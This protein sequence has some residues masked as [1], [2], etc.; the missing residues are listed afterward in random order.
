MTCCDFLFRTWGS[1]LTRWP[2]WRLSRSGRLD[3]SRGARISSS[4]YGSDLCK[5]SLLD[6]NFV[7]EAEAYLN[8]NKF[9]GIEEMLA[10]V[11]KEY[12]VEDSKINRN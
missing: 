12:D 11:S 3:S 6:P 4:S 2:R 8:K 7:K 10:K 9:A 1:V 5:E